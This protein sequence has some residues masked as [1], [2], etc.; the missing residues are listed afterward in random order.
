MSVDYEPQD[1]IP[2]V[3]DE[4]RDAAEMAYW[5]T[6]ESQDAYE[7]WARTHVAE[8]VE[9]PEDIDHLRAELEWNDR[10]AEEAY[11]EYLARREQ[12]AQTDAF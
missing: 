4:E 6:Q 7:A 8:A 2:I 3:T 11:Q 1:D 9:T 5:S 12:P 10:Q